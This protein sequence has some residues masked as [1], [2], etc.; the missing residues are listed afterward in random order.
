MGELQTLLLVT[1]V[2]KTTNSP[3]KLPSPICIFFKNQV[4]AVDLV[5]YLAAGEVSG[6][7]SLVPDKQCIG[8]AIAFIIV[9][10]SIQYN[11]TMVMIYLVHQE[12]PFEVGI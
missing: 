5:L 11:N 6:W 4:L 2:P 12:L 7:G 3:H 10:R 8:L 1:N 9:S